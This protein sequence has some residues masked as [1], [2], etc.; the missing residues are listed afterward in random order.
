MKTTTSTKRGP[1]K[2]LMIVIVSTMSFASFG[3]YKWELERNLKLIT[4]QVYA[5]STQNADLLSVRELRDSIRKMKDLKSTLLGLN[6]EYPTPVCSQENAQMMRTTF[7]SIKIFAYS[8]KGPELSTQEATEY[9][10]NWTNTYPCGYADSF[11][12]NYQIVKRF[13]H[14]S[15]SGLNLPK[16]DAIAYANEKTPQFC[17]DLSFKNDF[18]AAFKLARYEMDM[19]EQ[20]ARAYAQRVVERDHFTC[21]WDDLTIERN[22]DINSAAANDICVNITPIIV[23]GMPNVPGG[24]PITVTPR[25]P[26]GPRR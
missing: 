10:I 20:E 2:L 23:P 15:Q 9:A 22:V 13:A 16:A 24:M 14:T 4:R 18:W 26:R 8:I 17:G 7:K 11:E 25:G 1:M 19:P 21:R 5:L 3:N 6:R 12:R